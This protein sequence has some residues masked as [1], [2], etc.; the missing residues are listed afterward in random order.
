MITGDNENIENPE[1]QLEANTLEEKLTKIL[2]RADGE[3][4]CAVLE[5]YE[6]AHVAQRAFYTKLLLQD[7]KYDAK[8]DAT[9]DEPRE[10][11]FYFTR[12]QTVLIRDKLLAQLP[13]NSTNTTSVDMAQLYYRLGTIFDALYNFKQAQFYLQKAAESGHKIAC[14]RLGVLIGERNPQQARDWF[15][16][17]LPDYPRTYLFMATICYYLTF[18]E[19]KEY[20]DF[21]A[22]GAA[23]GCRYAETTQIYHKLEDESDENTWCSSVTRLMELSDQGNSYAL[24]FLGRILNQPVHDNKAFLCISRVLKYSGALFLY[25][26]AQKTNNKAVAAHFYCYLLCHQRKVNFYYSGKSRL[27]NEDRVKVKYDE[28]TAAINPEEKQQLLKINYFRAIALQD[29]NLFANCLIEDPTLM[30]K[31]L[32]SGIEVAPHTQESFFDYCYLLLSQV[33]PNLHDFPTKYTLLRMTHE[34]QLCNVVWQIMDCASIEPAHKSEIGCLIIPSQ[35]KLTSTT[36]STKKSHETSTLTEAVDH[37]FSQPATKLFGKAK[38]ETTARQNVKATRQLYALSF[39]LSPN[40]VNPENTTTS[41]VE[42]KHTSLTSVVTVSSDAPT[43][44]ADEKAAVKTVEKA[45][46]ESSAKIDSATD[47]IATVRRTKA[48]KLLP[49]CLEMSLP[50]LRMVSRCFPALTNPISFVLLCQHITATD[51]LPIALMIT[52]CEF[53]TELFD[54]VQDETSVV[55]FD[56]T[57]PKMQLTL[58]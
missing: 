54:A 58:S 17:A 55:A 32:D 42:H 8:A 27:D 12:E 26:M 21:L 46:R 39:F 56:S 6:Q 19:D 43:G 11:V 4:L 13:D 36:A 52:I 22:K 50:D 49:Q 35:I 41:S 14:A 30:I 7:E 25:D 1:E 24:G 9:H 31:I 44:S 38:D 45:T 37:F 29:L 34:H 15:N 23:N 51:L 3:R 2:D 5:N 40:V 57:A 53:A 47:Q 18:K 28:Y 33:L 20:F 10:R 16:K 48:Y